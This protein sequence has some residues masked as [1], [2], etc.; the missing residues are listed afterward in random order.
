[1]TKVTGAVK[2]CEGGLISGLGWEGRL[3]EDIFRGL[4]RRDWNGQ[5]PRGASVRAGIQ[6]TGLLINMSVHEEDD[7]YT[8]GSN[9]GPE[10]GEGKNAR[11]ESED[12][13]AIG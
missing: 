13:P 9:F 10:K 5:T 8:A 2:A 7:G 12:T 11:S 1:M 3:G 4:F 6:N